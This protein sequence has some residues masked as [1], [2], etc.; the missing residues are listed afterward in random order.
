MNA[1]LKLGI[2][3]TIG[4][5]YHPAMKIKTK[6]EAQAYLGLLVQHNM[7]LAANRTQEEAIR[8]EKSNLGYFA[9]YYDA[10]TMNRVNKLFNTTH[11]VFGCAAPSPEKALKIGMNLSKRK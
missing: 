8:I 1:K 3:A 4:D 7:S 2:A 5:K 9:G 10:K 6:K 11:P